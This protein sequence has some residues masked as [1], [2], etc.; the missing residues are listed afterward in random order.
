[1]ATDSNNGATY[2]SPGSQGVGRGGNGAAP[3][4][5][6]IIGENTTDLPPIN[7]GDMDSGYTAPVPPRSG[8]SIH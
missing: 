3:V 6:P 2:R 1:M 5:Q 8:H 7:D 4:A